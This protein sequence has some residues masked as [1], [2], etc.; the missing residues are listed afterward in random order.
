MKQSIQPRP[1]LAAE[2]VYPDESP[3]LESAGEA[4]ARRF[5]GPVGEFLLDV[6]SRALMALVQRWPE[7]N[8]LDVGGGHGQALE[9]L[10]EAGFDVTVLASRRESWGEAHRRF[11]TRV[12]FATGSLVR[13]PFERGNFDLVTSFRMLAH[14]GRW[15]EMIEGLCG[16][17][18]EAVIVDFPSASAIRHFHRPLFH[19]KNGLEGNTRPF[20]VFSLREVEREFERNGFERT[21]LVRQFGIPMVCHRALG[22]AAASRRLER[23]LRAAGFTDRLGSPVILLARRV[24]PGRGPEPLRD[25]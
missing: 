5:E 16:V 4:Y 23:W 13:P 8:A 24:G 14:V 22:N 19:L 6:Q 9:P 25:P 1:V 10:L 18:R 11:G 20:R 3:D 17:A 21:A 12:A 15:R 7:G 2:V